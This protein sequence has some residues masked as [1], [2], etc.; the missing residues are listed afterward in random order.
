MTETIL[1]TGA[2]G[3]V[4]SELVRL[5]SEQG[6]SVRAAARRPDAVPMLPGVVPA[7]FEVGAAAAL[8]E[9]HPKV[10]ERVLLDYRF[11]G[12]GLPI[13]K[14]LRAITLSLD[15]YCGVAA[16]LR[17]AAPIDFTVHVDGTLVASV[18]GSARESAVVAPRV[19]RGAQA[20]VASRDD[21]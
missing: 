20:H 8:T 10:F 1:V 13:D 16:M 9:S 18:E 2:T 19:A 14:L 3:N 5:L 12:T 21:A 4:G 15:R 6:A 11:S 17:R 7:R